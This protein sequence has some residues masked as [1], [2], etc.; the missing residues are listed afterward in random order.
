L[1]TFLNIE[2]INNWWSSRRH[3]CQ[4]HASSLNVRSWLELKLDLSE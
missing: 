4:H 1:A 3:T 2:Q